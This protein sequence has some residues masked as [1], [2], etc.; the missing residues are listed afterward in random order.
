MATAGGRLRSPPGLVVDPAHPLNC[1]TSIP[2]LVG[3]VV[4]PNARFYL[5]N[6]FHI[7]NLDPENH[8][9]TVGG[10]VERPLILSL[11]GIIKRAGG[12]VVGG[13]LGHIWGGWIRIGHPSESA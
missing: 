6:H 7:S 3:G 1:E 5:R 13:L 9:L 10:L 4:M 12:E 8:R 11:R 2:V